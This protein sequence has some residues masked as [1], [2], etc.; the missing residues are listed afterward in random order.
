[1]REDTVDTC[2]IQIILV[3]GYDAPERFNRERVY[4]LVMWQAIESSIFVG[5]VYSEI[6][7]DCSVLI[8][9]CSTYIG[10]SIAQEYIWWRI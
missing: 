8:H 7:F 10:K 2:A 5:M 4:V 1:M 3:S 6:R 9:T